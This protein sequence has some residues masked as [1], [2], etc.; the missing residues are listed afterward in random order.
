M[1]KPYYETGYDLHVANY[2][3]YAHTDNKLYEDAEHKTAVK[4]ADAEKAFKLGRLLI[5]TADALLLPVA[6]TTAGVICY[7]GSAA[8]TYTTEE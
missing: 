1:L 5:E 7:D 8:S 3:A 2:V 4:H 6:L